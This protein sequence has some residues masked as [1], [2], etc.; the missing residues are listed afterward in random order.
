MSVLV[1]ELAKNGTVRDYALR[2]E[3]RNE[4]RIVYDIAAGLKQMHVRG[5]CHRYELACFN[6]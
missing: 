5:I 6:I 2:K 1:L 3:N 4:K